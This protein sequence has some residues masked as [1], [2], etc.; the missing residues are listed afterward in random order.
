[1][2]SNKSAANFDIYQRL[3]KELKAEHFGEKEYEIT[4]HVVCKRIV[5]SIK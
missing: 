2:C 5:E 3:T 4:H 1:M